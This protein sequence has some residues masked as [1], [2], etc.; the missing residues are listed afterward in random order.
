M[1]KKAIVSFMLVCALVWAQTKDNVG[2]K[3]ATESER[4]VKLGIVNVEN[5]KPIPDNRTVPY[6]INYQGYLIDSA[7]GNPI[8]DNVS[9]IFSIWDAQSGG[10]QVWADTLLIMV[11][12]GLFN[13]VLDVSYSIFQSGQTRW[14]Q[15]KVN[16]DSLNPR[17]EIT[18]CPWAYTA[19]KS[20]SSNY[21]Y[22]SDK[23]D[24]YHAEFS[25]AN[26]IPYTDGTGKLSSAVIPPVSA[27]YADSAGGSARVGG[28]TLTGLDSR[29]VNEGQTAA[30]DLSGVYPNPTVD[31]LQ[32]RPVSSAAPTS[33]YVLKWDGSQWTPAQDQV[34]GNGDITAVYADSGLTG[35]ATSGD[36]HLNVG[37]GTGISVSADVV[38]FDQTWGHDQYVNEGQANSITSTMIQDGTIQ[39]IDMGFT[40]GDITSV[41]VISP[42]TGGG[43]SG[44]I[45]VG[46]QQASSSQNGYL[47]SSDWNTFNNKFGWGTVAS[48]L[49]DGLKLTATNGAGLWGIA[50]GVSQAGVRGEATGSGSAGVA[51]ISSNTSGAGVHGKYIGSDGIGVYGEGGSGTGVKGV[52][53]SNDGIVGISSDP[54]KAAVVGRN[55]AYTTWG[56]LGYRNYGIWGYQGSGS[57][58]G[59]FDG[60]VHVQGTLSKSAGSFVID[61]PLEPENKILRHSFV[62]GPEMML[63]YKGRAKLNNGEVTV[64]LPDYFDGLNHPEGREINLTCINGWSPL[65]LAG[66]IKNNQF[67]VKT[68]SQGNFE[69]EFS[70]IIYGVRNDAYARTHP[71]VVEEE[72]GSD[73]SFTKGKYIHPDAYTERK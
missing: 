71:I 20:D 67:T 73:N 2:K 61:H 31:G 9:M 54:N 46:I 17:T 38:S 25:G 11:E 72:K 62:E 68:T 18:S 8:N 1:I 69:Q 3:I 10:F 12:N 24:S 5:R 53:S 22:D 59:Y 47:S 30:G 39:Q 13:T 65:Y 26:V 27:S 15:L 50:N 57:Y 45:T 23:L 40:V 29:Y 33:G 64:N 58:A 55:D 32:N 44:D 60:N 6:R 41:N 48:G 35:G 37:A 43:T 51:G 28:L 70:W 14:M 56:G 16:E 4:N 42:L 36:A 34:G 19:T 66:E 49:G 52:S 21:S 63:I 7:T